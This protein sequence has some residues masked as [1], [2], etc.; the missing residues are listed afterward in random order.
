MSVILHIITAAR[1]GL[2]CSRIAR[3]MS[4]LITWFSVFL[5][6]A[7]RQNIMA[8]VIPP[9]VADTRQYWANIAIQHLCIAP[10]EN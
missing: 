5:L 4:G 1:A 10:V 6:L 9:K 8:Q 2:C 3:I 7:G